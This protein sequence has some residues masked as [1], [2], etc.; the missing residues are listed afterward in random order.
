MRAGAKVPPLVAHVVQRDGLGLD[1]I[2]DFQ[3]E[4]LPQGLDAR[5]RF[6]PATKSHPHREAVAVYHSVQDYGRSK[7]TNSSRF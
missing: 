7:V 5:T 3:L 6:F 4:R 1:G 2:Q